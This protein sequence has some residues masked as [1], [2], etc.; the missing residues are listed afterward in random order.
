MTKCLSAGSPWYWYDGSQI[1]YTNWA[2]GE[3]GDDDGTQNCANMP[4]DDS[5]GSWYSD[6]CGMARGYVCKTM[7]G[8][9]IHV[10]HYSVVPE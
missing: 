5:E 4:T 6:Q 7:K 1:V 3:P 8:V 2:E 9:Y 10:L